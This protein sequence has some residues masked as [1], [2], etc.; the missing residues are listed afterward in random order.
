[1]MLSNVY[2]HATVWRRKYPCTAIHAFKYS[3]QTELLL[4]SELV[5]MGI[6]LPVGTRSSVGHHK[7]IDSSA[8]RDVGEAASIICC[9]GLNRDEYSSPTIENSP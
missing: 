7:K 2:H 1:M 4:L 6:D 5:H 8:R 9:Q 3:H